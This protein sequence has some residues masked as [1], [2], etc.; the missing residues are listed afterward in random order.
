MN[1]W[2]L[3]LEYS[4]TFH[5]TIPGISNIVSFFQPV[6]FSFCKRSEQLVI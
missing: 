5:E 6:Y 3:L 4:D 1:A 2:I